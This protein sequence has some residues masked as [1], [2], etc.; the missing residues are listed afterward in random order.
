MYDNHTTSVL[1]ILHIFFGLGKTSSLL[2]YFSKY[3]QV[4]RKYV[5]EYFADEDLLLKYASKSF[6]II[7]YVS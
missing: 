6:V 1:H 2:C 3:I 7:R 4:M 5:Y